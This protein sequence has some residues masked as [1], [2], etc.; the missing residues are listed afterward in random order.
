MAM[1][2]AVLATS[3]GLSLTMAAP[4]SACTGDP[5]DGFCITYNGLPTAVKQKVFHSDTCPLR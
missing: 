2:L 3:A 1:A 4:A 5:C